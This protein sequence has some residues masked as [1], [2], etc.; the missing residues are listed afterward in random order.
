M[1]L[2]P[3][4]A[5]AHTP[6][7]CSCGLLWWPCSDVAPF[8]VVKAA[9]DDAD[10]IKNLPDDKA[11]QCKELDDPGDDFAGIDAVHTRK[12]EEDEQREQ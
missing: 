1:T 3:V 5:S 8:L 9:A 7:S 12:T 4:G 10:N 11:T 6:G 2:P